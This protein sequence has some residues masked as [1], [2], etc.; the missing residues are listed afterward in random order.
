MQISIKARST[1][2]RNCIIY[3]AASS[4]S[5]SPKLLLITGEAFPIWQCGLNDN[6]VYLNT[7]DGSLNSIMEWVAVA[8]SSKNLGDNIF[9]DSKEPYNM[10]ISDK[11]QHNYGHVHGLRMEE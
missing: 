1:N 10:S 4:F 2:N 7:I 6:R 11:K 8:A 3:S 9:F 5:A